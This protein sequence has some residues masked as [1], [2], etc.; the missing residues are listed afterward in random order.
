MLA[1]DHREL[2]HRQPIVVP[3]IGEVHQSNSITCD[4]AVGP[5][6]FHLHAIAQHVMEDA[7]VARQRRRFLP[8][9]LVQRFFPRLFG[10]GRVQPPDRLA[11]AAHQHHIAER[12]PLRRRLTRREMRPVTDGVAQFPEPLQRGF[13]DMRFV[14]CAHGFPGLGFF[15]FGNFFKSFAAFSKSASTA[16]GWKSSHVR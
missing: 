16:R 11:Q 13:F 1:V 3:D 14:E 9:H 7:V 4:G 15:G 10:N 5:T 2:V 6:V 12:S 8:Q